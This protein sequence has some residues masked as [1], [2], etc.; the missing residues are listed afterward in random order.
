MKTLKRRAQNLIVDYL[1]LS[2]NESLL[3]VYHEHMD[4]EVRD[5]IFEVSSELGIHCSLFRAEDGFADLSKIVDQYCVVLFLEDQKSTF[6]MQV[7]HSIKQKR[8]PDTKFFRFYNAKLE[9][10]DQGFRERREELQSINHK[11]ISLGSRAKH[12]SVESNIGTRITAKVDSSFGWVDSCGTFGRLPGVL[13]PSEVATFSPDVNGVIVADGCLAANMGLEWDP[14]LSAHPVKLEIKDS[15]VVGWECNSPVVRFL[16]DRYFSRENT[17]RV[18]ELGF[19]TNL[20]MKEFFPFFCHMNER[21]PSF[22]AGLGAHHQGILCDWQCS[23]H[24]DV[25]TDKCRIYFDDNLVH[26]NNN[27]LLPENVPPLPKELIIGYA[28][29]I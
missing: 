11:L 14:R 6:S 7:I 2:E 23:F 26:E 21:Y 15:I 24:L 17:R 19:G 5:A 28:D 12:I 4:M 8:C 3:I 20:G 16:L 9:V 18:G 29:T 22:H 13:P 25:M 10:L 1:F 27:Y